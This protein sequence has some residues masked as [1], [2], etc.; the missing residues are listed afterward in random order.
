M[1]EKA[2]IL[3]KFT[4]PRLKIVH[5]DNLGIAKS[6]NKG[7]KLSRSDII[8]RLDADDYSFP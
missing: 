5:Q 3:K 7:V 1:E 2:E 8:A 6:L 4:D